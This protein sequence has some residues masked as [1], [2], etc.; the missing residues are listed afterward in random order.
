M[1]TLA[2][3]VILA[4]APTVPCFATIIVADS[5]P[6][7]GFGE[8]VDPIDY[9]AESWIQSGTFGAVTIT[10][11]L[12]GAGEGGTA[13]LT[14]ALGPGA[15]SA[16]QVAVAGFTFPDG[17]ATV[18]LFSGLTLGPATYYLLLTGST[19]GSDDGWVDTT[20]PSF[21]VAPGVTS[22]PG[23]VFNDAVHLPGNYPPNNAYSADSDDVIFSVTGSSVPE[24][25]TS[26]TMGAALA[27]LIAS[28]LI[29]RRR[30]V[31]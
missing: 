27:M 17:V 25:G 6:N 20:S 14:T 29:V 12:E 7:A 30:R 19:T 8:S 31:R 16:S 24:P 2:V 13:Y 11:F 22:V 28:Q 26:V 1:R 18:T 9:V 4:C 23:I 15:T 5:G 3:F 10:A 21:T